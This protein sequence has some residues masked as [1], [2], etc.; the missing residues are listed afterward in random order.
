M[1]TTVVFIVGLLVAFV[2]GAG[3]GY[4][5]RSVTSPAPA[6]SPAVAACPE[7]THPEVW[8]TAQTWAC[9]AGR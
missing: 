8:Y 6:A 1:R 4:A 5:A 2:I 3:G 7:G 9:V